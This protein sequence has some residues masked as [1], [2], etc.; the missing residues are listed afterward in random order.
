MA[1]PEPGASLLAV[2]DLH[3]YYGEIHALKG[4]SFR[5]SSGE[6]VTLLCYML[7]V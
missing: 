6:I 1:G 5:V 7:W 3:V 2:S 4:V